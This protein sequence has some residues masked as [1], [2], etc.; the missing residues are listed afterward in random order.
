MP[1][2][3]DQYNTNNVVR[4]SKITAEFQRKRNFPEISA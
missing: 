4:D 1:P 2:Q 3:Q